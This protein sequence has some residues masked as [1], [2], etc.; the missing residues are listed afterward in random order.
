MQTLNSFA[1]HVCSL[2]TETVEARAHRFHSRVV[3]RSGGSVSA[4]PTKFLLRYP[5]LLS[6]S[7][8]YPH[9]AFATSVNN[10]QAPL[11]FQIQY[12]SV[13]NEFSLNRI[14]YFN[15]VPPQD[16]FGFNPEN[17]NES[18]EKDA[19][20]QISDD[21][22]IVFNHPET[23]NGEERDQYVRSTSPSKVTSGSKSFI[24]QSSI[25]G[26]RK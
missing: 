22:Q 4:D 23:V 10:G 13:E 8:G 19:N 17:V 20:N 1:N 3:G 14:N 11:S 26:D 9:S 21:L 16:E 12:V 6:A 24:H 5:F 18:A 2:S 7:R 25:A 15:L